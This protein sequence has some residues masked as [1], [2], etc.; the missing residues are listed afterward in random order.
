VQDLVEFLVKKIVNNPDKVTISENVDEMD[1]TIITIEADQEDKP[2]L[3]G[4]GGRNITAVR[5]LVKVIARKENKRVYIKI[6]D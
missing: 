4:K 1:N 3:I 6:S 5:E 2:I